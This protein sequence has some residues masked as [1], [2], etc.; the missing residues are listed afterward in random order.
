VKVGT[1]LAIG[2]G[3]GYFLGRTKKMRL[4][5][6]LVAA[7]ATGKIGSSPGELLQQGAK[8]VG[9]SPELKGLTEDVKGRLLE[10]GKAAAVATAGRQIGS[11]TDKL[12]ERTELLR[13]PG[14]LKGQDDDEDESYE[15]DE[16]DDRPKKGRQARGDED[17]PRRGR[18]SRDDEDEGDE[19]DG[20]AED[21]PRRGRA[22]R[23]GDDEDR[24]RRGR[25][26]R[27]DEDDDE[28]EDRPRR[29]RAARGGDDE[30]GPRRGRAARDEEDDDEA[31]AEEDD[32]EEIEEPVRP[33]RSAGTRRRSPVRRVG[34]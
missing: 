1:R 5:L 14:D 25:A 4:A 27:D 20:E 17:R 16:E 28:G 32:D 13:Q 29:G 9:S 19:D 30:D 31:E 34:R 7:G 18:A 11:L 3:I 6:M 12:Q 15:D 8:M 33:R 21:R 2:V 22:S 24:P 23:G 26:S 10:A